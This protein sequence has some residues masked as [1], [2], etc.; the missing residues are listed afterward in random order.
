MNDSEVS[1]ASLEISEIKQFM[2]IIDAHLDLAMNAIEW[3]RDLSSGI[4]EKSR[5]EKKE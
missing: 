4:Q 2:F 3:N 5:T 1:K